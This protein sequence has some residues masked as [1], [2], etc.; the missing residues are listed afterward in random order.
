MGP[1]ISSYQSGLAAGH[2]TNLSRQV[3][4]EDFPWFARHILHSFVKSWIVWLLI[5]V[6][7]QFCLSGRADYIIL[8]LVD[9]VARGSA[10]DAIQLRS[11]ARALRVA[12]GSHK[13]LPRQLFLLEES[14]IAPILVVVLLAVIITDVISHFLLELLQGRFIE[15]LYCLSAV[16]QRFF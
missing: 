8:R 1:L 6:V 16:P 9:E 10:S 4:L 14:A 5:V 2:A 13:A 12:L 3:L 7:L 15:S 11:G